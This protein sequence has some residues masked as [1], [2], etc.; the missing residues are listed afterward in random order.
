MPLYTYGGTASAV[1]T[2]GTG[3]VVP[4]YPV[5]VRVAGTGALI[6]ALY[7]ADG[8]TPIAQLRSNP[9]ASNAPGAIRAFTVPDVPAIEYEYLDRAGQ[10][11]RWYEP[12]R[13]LAAAAL[14]LAQGALPRSG[15]TMTGTIQTEGTT[16][17]TVNTAGFV[18]GDTH[19]RYRR[20][21]GGTM[22]WGPGT[23]ARDVTLARSGPNTLTLTGNLIVT[24]QG[25]GAVS[26]YVP[27]AYGA[28]G[29][30]VANDAPA[31]QQALNAAR[32]AGGGWVVIPPGTYRAATLPLRIY[33]NTRLT[34][35]PGAVIV[36][37]AA[38]TLLLNGDAG[39]DLGGYTGHGNLLIEGGRWEMQATAPGLTANAM[40]ISLGHAENITVRDLEVRD[41]P[42][43]HAIELNAIRGAL[44]EGCRFRGYVDPGGRSTS[45][46][47]QL[48][49]AAGSGFFGGFGPYDFT[50]CEN[51]LVHGCT[52]GASGTAGT[53]AWPR[54]VGSHSSVI[55]RW[56]R[57]IRVTD[58]HF[59]GLLQAGV[60]TYAW[61]DT[62]V[63]DCAFRGCGTG[64]QARTVDV[65]RPGDTLDTS[66][67]QT[68]ASQAQAGLV[69]TGNTVTDTTGWQEGAIHVLGEATGKQTGVTIT[70]NVVRGVSGGWSGVRL[71]HVQRATVTGNTIVGVTGTG[72]SQA[73]VDGALV[74]GNTVRDCTLSGVS[75]NTGTDVQ[76]ADNHISLVGANGVHI[77]G[78]V[79]T[80]I[81][82]NFVR[83][84]GRTDGTGFGFRVTTASAST[85]IT[86][87]TYRKHGSGNEAV[88]ALGITG[89][90]TGV[91]RWGNDWLGQGRVADVVDSSTTPNLSPYDAGTP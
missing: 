54:G 6:T 50:P 30:G 36:R 23:A 2:T 73:T 27:Q 61:E 45:E 46:A 5:N 11:V 62:I 64:I 28:R 31:I 70:D 33:R 51:I 60:R 14:A 42:G 26:A 57:R 72:I 10:P 38:A 44:I 82:D 29:D 13:E 25:G 78:G 58:S 20:T 34:L 43:Y 56:H 3:D 77:V 1:L 32:N 83:S 55:G 74:T 9:T 24:G 16:A 41:V 65:S 4:D 12:S 81:A 68:G 69:I 90:N 52:F 79:N 76:I 40:C 8:V 71:E 15:G 35:M 88:N 75:A 39:Q 18:T 22:T 86:N 19:D 87:N 91:R 84:C 48:D 7:E 66:G 47:V 89:G 53:T 17:A 80:R 85:T 49:L 67:A 21:S 37:A 63:A 59:D